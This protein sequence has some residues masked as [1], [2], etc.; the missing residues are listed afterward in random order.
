MKKFI[1]VTLALIMLL[2]FGALASCNEK[3]SV[4]RITLYTTSDSV[5]RAVLHTVGQDDLPVVTNGS[6]IFD[7]WYYDEAFDKPF[8]Y[9]DDIAEGTCLYAKWKQGAADKV[10]LTLNLDY[11]GSTPIVTEIDKN[12]TPHLDT[13]NRQGYT[14]GGWFTE[15]NGNGIQWNDTKPVSADLTLYA[16]WTSTGGGNQGGDEPD[17]TPQPTPVDLSATLNKYVDISSWNFAITASVADSLGTEEYYNEYLGGLVT[18]SYVGSDGNDYIDYY[19]MSRDDVWYL[20]TVNDNGAYVKY[21]DTTN[22]FN[23]YYSYTT[24]ID[25]SYLAD[26]TYVVSGDGYAAQNPSALGNAVLGD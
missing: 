20:Y 8:K 13:P 17:P 16:K 19:D 9:T 12:S 7:G 2:T 3:A 26:Y 11:A 1:T 24:I 18:D 25:V 5:P 10:T 6:L 4:V 15:A 23:E 21:D 14:F 22:E